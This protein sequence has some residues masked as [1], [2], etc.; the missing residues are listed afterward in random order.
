MQSE[1]GSTAG[2]ILNFGIGY[3][4]TQLFDLR[5]QVPTFFISGGDE[6][7]GKVVPTITITAGLNF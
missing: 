7:D 3:R 2:V 4:F 5:A 6:R 1:E